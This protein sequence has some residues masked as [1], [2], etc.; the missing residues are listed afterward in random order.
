MA[1]GRK[2]INFIPYI[3]KDGLHIENPREIGRSFEDHFCQ[4][5]GQKR[6][7]RI[8]IDFRKLVEFKD[9]VNLKGLERRFTLEEIKWAVFELGRDKAPGP[10]G[11]PLH[12]F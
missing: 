10:D 5:F 12:F 1:N 9:Q 4:L 8:N 2:N 11:F 6:Y 7:A 3:S